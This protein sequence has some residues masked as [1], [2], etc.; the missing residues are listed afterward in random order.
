[1]IYQNKNY[2]IITHRIECVMM[3]QKKKIYD[4]TH[5][6]LLIM[7]LYVIGDLTKLSTPQGNNM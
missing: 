7:I 2:A 3:K 4:Q 5:V 6:Q 1:M